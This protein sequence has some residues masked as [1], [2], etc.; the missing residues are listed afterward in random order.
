LYFTKANGY[1]KAEG[2][3][4][5]IIKA[6]GRGG[7]QESREEQRLEEQKRG[8]QSRAEC[9]NP[10]RAEQ[11]STEASRLQTDLVSYSPAPPA[12]STRCH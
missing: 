3:I 10:G 5:F 6:E 1:I 8:C 11:S 7:R 9:S 2:Y 12:I 4:Y